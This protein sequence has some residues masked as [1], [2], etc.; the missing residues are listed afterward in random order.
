VVV[1]LGEV[2]ELKVVAVTVSHLAWIEGTLGWPGCLVQFFRDP[3]KRWCS[4][5]VLS[6]VS[7]PLPWRPASCRVAVASASPFRP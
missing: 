3:M 5:M 2:R 7:T 1:F 4:G 6:F